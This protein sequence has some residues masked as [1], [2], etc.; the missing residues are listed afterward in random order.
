MLFSGGCGTITATNP[1]APG[2]WFYRFETRFYQRKGFT[3]PILPLH[4]GLL[5]GK[6]ASCMFAA[7]RWSVANDD[8]G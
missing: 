3:S 2:A 6:A 5:F 8:Y 1:V 4:C 7:S